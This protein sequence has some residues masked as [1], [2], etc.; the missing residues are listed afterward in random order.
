VKKLEMIVTDDD[1]KFLR[2]NHFLSENLTIYLKSLI[3]EEEIPFDYKKVIDLRYRIKRKALNAKIFLELCKEANIYNLVFE[4]RKIGIKGDENNI[5]KFLKMFDVEMKDFLKSEEQLGV[6]IYKKD[7]DTKKF[8]FNE[9]FYKIFFMKLSN[10]PKF[11]EFIPIYL[12]KVDR[13]IFIPGENYE[14]N[15]LEKDLEELKPL[16][17]LIKILLI[18]DDKQEN[19]QD[20]IQDHDLIQM[21]FND[22]SLKYKMN[23]K[24][25]FF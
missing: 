22:Q 20:L 11:S 2:K 18:R 4:K 23:L 25:I 10:T 5:T 3:N 15:E 7:L 1:F 16:K 17:N 8:Y 24:R 21:D 14:T 12:K 19:Y 13:V 6:S 9:K